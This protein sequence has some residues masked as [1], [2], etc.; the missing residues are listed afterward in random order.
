M[1]AV[2]RLD[3]ALV[4][5]SAP[6]EVRS[7]SSQFKRLYMKAATADH[8]G[9][10]RLVRD[11]T[12]V[13]QVTQS[14]WGNQCIFYSLVEDRP[15]A[16]AFPET[17]LWDFDTLLRIKRILSTGASPDAAVPL[18]AFGELCC[19]HLL[20]TLCPLF[21][22]F[23]LWFVTGVDRA[24]KIASGIRIDGQ[25]P[26]EIRFRLGEHSHGEELSIEH[27]HLYLIDS[28][29]EQT[30]VEAPDCLKLTPFLLYGVARTHGIHPP[31][32][33]LAGGSAELFVFRRCDE[34]KRVLYFLQFAYGAKLQSEISDSSL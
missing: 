19:L 32:D 14:S 27:L 20:S 3:R 28:T 15:F 23:R 12:R 1:V 2:N 4:E 8:I 7:A 5:S 6:R 26:L 13:L 11:L 33:D 24:K 17:L 10:L 25:M 34:T 9:E 29:K 31:T 22:R 16:K 30:G 18:Y 21:G